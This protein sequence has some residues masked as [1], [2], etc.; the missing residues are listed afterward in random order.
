MTPQAPTLLLDLNPAPALQSTLIPPHDSFPNRLQAEEGS[1]IL[2]PNEHAKAR[3]IGKDYWLYVVFHCA[4][5]PQLIRVS[6]PAQMQW[7]SV[8]KIEY[9]TIGAKA[10]REAEG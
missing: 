5:T 4:T 1:I 3:V 2:T 6:D 10:I 8:T 7:Q 9:H